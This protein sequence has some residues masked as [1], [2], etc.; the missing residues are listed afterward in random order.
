MSEMFRGFTD[1]L[2]KLAKAS[3]EIGPSY[4][5]VSTQP[6]ASFPTIGTHQLPPNVPASKPHSR[7]HTRRR[8][9]FGRKPSNY[10]YQEEP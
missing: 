4:A 9:T 5:G 8:L 2:R 7:L 3:S 10:S 1:E 6:A